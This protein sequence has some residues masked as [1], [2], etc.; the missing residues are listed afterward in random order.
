M[1]GTY[2]LAESLTLTLQPFAQIGVQSIS[3]DAVG[4]V[5]EPS[6]WAMGLA[7]FAFLA[8]FGMKR[9]RKDRLATI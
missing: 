7:G 6:T 8:F 9:A 1:A 3:M 4:Q 5:P 2:G